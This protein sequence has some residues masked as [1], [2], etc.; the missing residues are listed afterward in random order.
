MKR[1][2]RIAATLSLLTFAVSFATFVISTFA[3]WY[4][5]LIWAGLT[6]AVSFFI[7]LLAAGTPDNE[8]YLRHIRRSR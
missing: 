3:S 8:T 5:N 4:G 6:A 2:R 7:L 1:I